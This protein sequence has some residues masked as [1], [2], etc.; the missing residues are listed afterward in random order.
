MLKTEGGPHGFA[1]DPYNNVIYDVNH[2]N[3]GE[4][5]GGLNWL[6]GFVGL[7]DGQ[8]SYGY[9]FNMNKPE[10][11]KKFW[12]FGGG[13]GELMLAPVTISDPAAARA[14]FET[15]TGREWDYNFL[16]NNC[17]H[18]ACQGFSAG[19]ANI[20]TMGPAPQIWVG[21]FFIGRWKSSMDRPYVMNGVK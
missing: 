11:A 20:L 9:K 1:Y 12:E 16:S 5:N 13:R 17:K 4:T 10:E 15:N 21:S 2:P 19:G 14:F 6:A 8:K 3:G 7:S 18:Y